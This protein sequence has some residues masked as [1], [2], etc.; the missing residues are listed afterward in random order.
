[1]KKSSK[2]TK[3]GLGDKVAQITDAIGIEKCVGCEKRQED[4]NILG[5]QLEY[6]FKKFNPNPFTDDDIIEWDLF[7]SRTQPVIITDYEQ[8]LIIRLLKDIL[9][10]S[11]KY[12]KDYD[13]QVWDKYIRMIQTVYDRDLNQ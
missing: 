7:R 6:F 3:K 2:R 11:V 8:R 1:M 12:R 5:H 9:N 10:M 13:N 4:L